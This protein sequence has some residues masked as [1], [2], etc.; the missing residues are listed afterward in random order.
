[1]VFIAAETSFWRLHVRQ[2]PL[3]D[4][5]QPK[6]RQLRL[7]WHFYRVAYL[8]LSGFPKPLKKQAFDPPDPPLCP[9]PEHDLYSKHDD[10]DSGEG[11][12]R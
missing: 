10:L 1:M 4:R 5:K 6:L 11:Q 7:L 9:S 8:L 3:A 12:D 2:F